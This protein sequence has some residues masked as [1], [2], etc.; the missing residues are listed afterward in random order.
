MNL[1][2][3]VKMKRNIKIKVS[4]KAIINIFLQLFSLFV[5]FFFHTIKI[6]FSHSFCLKIFVSCFFSP[7]NKNFLQSLFFHRFFLLF[8]NSGLQFLSSAKWVV[9][10]I[11][12]SENQ[13]N[14]NQK[15]MP[16]QKYCLKKTHV[17]L[18]IQC[19]PYL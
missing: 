17:T 1:N 13:F 11:R 2:M 4:L 7:N 15:S 12:F 3:Y 16:F 8:S 6:I 19:L 14:N 5:T 18:L 10:R 9:F